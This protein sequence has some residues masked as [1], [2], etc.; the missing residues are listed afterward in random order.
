MTSPMK[1]DL[2]IEQQYVGK[3]L[4]CDTCGTVL[5]IS[6]FKPLEHIFCPNCKTE[7]VIPAKL[8]IYQ[9]NTF[10][11]EGAM[12]RVYLAKDPSLDRNV[13]I[14]ILRE[15]LNATP[16][17]WMMLEEE[18][19]AAAR[20]H[21]NNVI[22]IYTMGKVLG[23]PYIVME[24]A[25]EASL[26]DYMRE[27]SVSESTAITLAIDVLR[28]LEAAAEHQLMHGDVKPA[29]ILVGQPG[30]TKIADFGLARFM[31][32]GQPV[33]KWG[34]PYYIAPEKSQQIM[35]DHRS[36]LYSLGATL[37]HAVAGRAPFEGETGEEV[38]QKSLEEEHPVLKDLVPDIS[39][40]FSGCISTLM[41]RDI[42]DRFDTIEQALSCF[43]ALRDGTF[44]P[45]V[46]E[47]PDRQDS[48]VFT[49]LRKKMSDLLRD[50]SQ[51]GP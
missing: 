33:E 6:S 51:A 23:R 31:R 22:H 16:K 13:A 18:A 4:S 12:G 5:D 40:A 32:E 9:L 10:L 35:E 30:Y 49:R 3:N 21:H 8:G 25:T 20:I 2:P 43:I 42:N 37:F 50:E 11:G 38:I 36:D 47:R 14:K 24:L 26:E 15:D 7:T 41:A 17:M 1:K 45:E 48:G 29:N 46:L 39:E 19:K 27:H 44:D 28:G 34:T